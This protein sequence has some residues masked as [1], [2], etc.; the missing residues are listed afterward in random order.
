M[1]I[2]DL[3]HGLHRGIPDDVYHQRHPGL[4][5]KSALDLIH[6]SP[7]HYKAW[8]DGAEGES[9]EALDFGRAF[10]CAML[11]P[12]L[13]AR[14]YYVEPDFGDCRFKEAKAKRD[15]WRKA[16]PC[17]EN[18]VK[19]SRED[20]DAIKSMVK[21]VR[22]HPLASRIIS[23]G[24]VEVTLRWKDPD[25][26]LECK[27]RADYYVRSRRLVADIKTSADASK[28][29]FRRSIVNYRYH[30]QD[31]LYRAGFGAIGQPIEHFV[32]V[33]VEKKAPFA[34]AEYTLTSDGIQRGYAH[35]TADLAM[36]AECI[37]NN[38][39]P[40]YPVTIQQLDLPPWAA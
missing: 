33:V 25:T 9:S 29:A 2:I 13:F 40:G 20:G 37:R 7:L 39:F 35:A 34:V 8:L 18:A 28:E 14:S 15:E 26:G 4:A 19:L 6:R 36:L 32:F 21:S 11:E 17:P 5:S 27:S 23:E 22:E 31:A 24:D 3:A 30:V 38:D 10:H 1:K 12:D 16:N